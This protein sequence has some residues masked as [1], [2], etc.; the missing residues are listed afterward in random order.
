[1]TMEHVND[2]EQFRLRRQTGDGENTAFSDKVMTYYK[3]L[4][5]R[6]PNKSQ[7]DVRRSHDF[8]CGRG[9]HS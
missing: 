8:R 6:V 4:L 5:F 7:P 3:S 9:M 2:E 1:M